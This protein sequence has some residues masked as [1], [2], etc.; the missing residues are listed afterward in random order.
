MAYLEKS[1]LFQIYGTYCYILLFI[2]KFTVNYSIFFFFKFSI[3]S[4]FAIPA[5]QEYVFMDD[6]PDQVLDWNE[7][8]TNS[9]I[10]MCNSP[11]VGVYTKI[12]TFYSQ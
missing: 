1:E 2:L 12:K 11:S 4:I 6:S 7:F 3:N 8:L 9:L 5:N 10:N